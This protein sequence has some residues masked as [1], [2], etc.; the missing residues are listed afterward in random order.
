VV[1]VASVMPERTSFS[2]RQPPWSEEAEISVL[3][4]MLIDGD[5][6]ARAI[7]DI[8][9]SAF[10]KEAN[11]RVYRAMVRLYSRGEVIDPVTLSDELKSAAELE[12][13]G[14]MA[15]LARLVDAVP[16]SANIEYHCRILRDKS[17]LRR[18]IESATDIIQNA[19]EAPAG[20]VDETLDRAESLIF[21]IAQASR[22][23]GFVPIKSVLWPTFERIEELQR[24]PGAVTGVASGFADLD[25]LTAGFQRGDLVV[26]AGRP[27]M[28]KT[29]LALNFAQHA[30]IAGEVPT[31]IFSLEM[32]KESLV[33]RM[34]CAEGRVDAGRLRR[35]RL[36]DDEYTRLATAAGHLNTAPIWIDDSP[37]ISPLEL[38]AKA[39]RLAADA[40]IGLLL[41]D[42]MQL[43]TGPR[44]VENRQ[45]EISAIS[46]ALKAIAKELNL[47]VIALSQLSRGPEQRTE[48]RPLLSDLRESGAIEQDADLVMFVYREEQY[49]KEGDMFDESGESLEGKAELIIGKQRNGP[50]G[51][52]HLYFHKH[53]TLFESVTRRGAGAEG[54]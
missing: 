39:R 28:G 25:N 17:I 19:Y 15:Y 30:A 6:V 10:Y 45:Q 24:S 36:R 1:E 26:V 40:D 43:M 9:E 53:Y 4:A 51:T 54:P 3:S 22:R 5:A 27:S 23:Q 13:V 21:Q 50:T 20:D 8:D 49:R 52:V 29:A 11:R 16:T 38:R 47:P 14:G 42:Y 7:E 12:G 31:A 18:L 32:S 46:R 48:H 33:Q 2:G 37:A 35:G 34:L 41:V 44:N